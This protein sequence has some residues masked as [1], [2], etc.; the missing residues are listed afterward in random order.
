MEIFEGLNARHYA[1]IGLGIMLIGWV[2]P[3]AV[4]GGILSFIGGFMF[5]FNIVDAVKEWREEYKKT[6]KELEDE[7]V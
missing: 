3:L 4:I 1:S 2:T 5:G 6:M 7:Q